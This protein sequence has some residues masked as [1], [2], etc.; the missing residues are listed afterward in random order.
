MKLPGSTRSGLL[1]HGCADL[2]L[3]SALSVI[4]MRPTVSASEVFP[5]Q[6]V[7]IAVGRKCATTYGL[8]NM[9]LTTSRPRFAGND[10]RCT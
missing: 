2:A 6:F 4:V 10:S 8:I 1:G 3:K 7:W 5:D 9:A